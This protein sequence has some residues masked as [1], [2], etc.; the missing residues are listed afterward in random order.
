LVDPYSVGSGVRFNPDS[1]DYLEYVGDIPVVYNGEI[2]TWWPN[3]GDGGFIVKGAHVGHQLHRIRSA[4]AY[5]ENP[6]RLA[7][8]R[9]VRTAFELM[10][11]EK[12]QSATTAYSPGMR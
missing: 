6:D 4:I 5:V 9:V 11:D 8:F 12:V 10:E 7:G 2:M 3:G 1:P